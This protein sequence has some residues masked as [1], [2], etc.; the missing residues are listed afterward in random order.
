MPVITNPYVRKIIREEAF[1]VL[2]L[3]GAETTQRT[4]YEG[5]A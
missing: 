1:K 5:H 4:R 2:P 3:N